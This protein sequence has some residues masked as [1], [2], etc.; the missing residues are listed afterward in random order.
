MLFVLA[1]AMAGASAI[2]RVVRSAI[3]PNTVVPERLPAAISL[4]SGSTS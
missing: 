3:V 2:E 4:T 1:A